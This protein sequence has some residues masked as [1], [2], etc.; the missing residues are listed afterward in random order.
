[1][2]KA[3]FNY[4]HI[5]CI[6]ISLGFL[7]CGVFVFPSAFDRVIESGRDFG[8]SIAYYFCEIFGIEHSIQPSINELPSTAPV[9]S[10]P[11]T[12]DGFKTNFTAYWQLW[13]SSDNFVAYLTFIVS[14]LYV[15]GKVLVIILP[16]VVVFVLLFKHYLKK[17]NNDYNK[18]S[19]PLRAYKWLVAHTYSPVKTWLICMWAFIKQ[20][21]AYWVT[22]LCM[23]LYFFNAFTILLEFLAYYFYFVVSFDILNLYRQVYKLCLDLYTALS[24]I[25]LWAWAIIGLL[26]LDKFRKDIA[27]ARLNHFEMK[28]RGF[29][30]ARPIVFML[31]AT[32]GKF[33]TT[34]L[35]D[36]G[37]SGTVMFRDKAFEKLL[38]NDLKFPYFTWINLENEIKR[39]MKKHV[40]YNLATIKRW[41]RSKARRFYEKPSQSRIF[42]YDY[43]RYGITYDDKLK[44]VDVWEII[45]NYAQLYFIYIIQSSLLLSNYSVRVDDV[46]MDLGNF[47]LWNSDFFRR[48]S[49]LLDAYSRHAH[50]L[51]FDCLRLGRKLAENSIFA[52]S[53]E[54]G[55]V[56]VTEIGKERG[57]K[58]ELDGIKK[59]DDKTNQKN[60]GFNSGLKMIRHS[61]TV[62]NYSFIKVATD[63]QRPA[64]WG[65]DAKELCD[66]VHIRDGGEIRLAMPFFTLGELLYSWLYG[67][68][69]SAYYNYRFMRG[70]NTLFMYLLKSI[71]AKLRH[72][73]L[74]V[75]NRF[76]YRTLSVQVENGTQ[77]GNYTD[78]KYYLMTK[79]IYAKRFSTDCFAD[80][81]EAKSLR[82]FVGLDDIPEYRTEKATFEEMQLQHSYFVNDLLDGL[83]NGDNE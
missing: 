38:E 1:M 42:G 29:I 68:F 11:D 57:N 77:D 14:I 40:I 56:L 27:Y 64:S 65:A 13:A 76:G 73:Y 19:R 8:L 33:K 62:D 47:P 9:I 2:S 16:V 4:R 81:F 69:T 52:N 74:S 39:L 6:I 51:D 49:R 7:A 36:M 30:N 50:I 48:D 79:K 10:I 80:Y 75:Y 46:L 55:F 23:W 63:E 71:T 24:F 83:R 66:I 60:D 15:I 70:D 34:T 58:V 5:I 41:V 20:H 31:C 72:Y 32:M 59:K 25:P 18:D 12:W 54:F 61:A 21:K 26:L 28:N 82:S 53:F 37:L 78:N 67:K 17:E 3:R 35:T 22:W 43:E 44:V 45:S